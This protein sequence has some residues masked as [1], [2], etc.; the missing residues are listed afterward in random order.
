MRVPGHFGEWLQGRL[1]AGGPVVLV[2]VA[3]PALAVRA[4]RLGEGPLS[5]LQGRCVLDPDQ[6]RAL[7]DRLGLAHG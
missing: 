5:L 4:T 7:L 3:C 6:A 1:G 2:T